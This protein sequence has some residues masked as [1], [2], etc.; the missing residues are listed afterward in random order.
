[1]SCLHELQPLLDVMDELN[2]IPTLL[3]HHDFKY[4]IALGIIYY[5]KIH[6]FRSSLCNGI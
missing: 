5:D 1:M 3:D 6:W 4:R 2:Q